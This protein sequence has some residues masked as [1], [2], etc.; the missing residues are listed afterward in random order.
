MNAVIRAAKAKRTEEMKQTALRISAQY[1]I[2]G[3]TEEL[4]DKTG[5]IPDQ[6]AFWEALERGD[7]LDVTLLPLSV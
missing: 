5:M 4:I 6:V 3:Y 7:H 1:P 2:T